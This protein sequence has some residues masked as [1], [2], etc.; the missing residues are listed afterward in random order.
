MSALAH[1]GR[2]IDKKQLTAIVR[3]GEGSAWSSSLLRNLGFFLFPII[4]RVASAAGASAITNS[5]LT[6]RMY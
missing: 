5:I 6:K 3:A 2:A 4:M 1:I